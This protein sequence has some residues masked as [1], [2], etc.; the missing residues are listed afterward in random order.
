M[1]G[2]Q[3]PCP[4]CGG[5]VKFRIS[6]SLV[7]VCPFCKSVVARGD[8]ALED[9]GKVADVVETESPLQ[10]GL[11][12]QYE[13]KRL[14]LVGRSQYRHAAGGVWDEWY[15]AFPGDR[16]GWLAEAQ[17]RFYLTFEQKNSSKI[18]LP[19]PGELTLGG[20]V[21]M[22]EAGALTV[23][24]IGR[25]EALTAEGEIPFRFVPGI[26]HEYA[27]LHGPENT[28]ATLS[29]GDEGPI[30]FRG[31][32][33]TLDQLG[34]DRNAKGP[35]REPKAISALHVSCPRCAGPLT[36]VAPDQTQRVACP[37]CMSLLDATQG[38]LKYLETLSAGEY[39][40]VIPLGTIGT[41]SGVSYHVIGFVVRSVT[42]DDTD[43]FWT[44]YLLYQPIDGFRWLVHSDNH[45]SFV[46]PISAGAV[47]ISPGVAHYKGRRF[48]LFQGADATVRHVLGEFYWKVTVGERVRAT[49]F[50]APP[51]ML[52]IESSVEDE[53][54]PSETGPS[55]REVN[56]SLGTYMPHETIEQAFGVS[57]LRR[58]FGVAPNQ[59]SPVDG[60]VYVAWGLF[61][62]ILLILDAMVS[63][64][65]A[66]TGID[67]SFLVAALAL[68]SVVPVGAMIYGH[69]FERSRWK[70][71]EY[72]PY[73][74]GGGDDDDD[75]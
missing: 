10:I 22:G 70:D 72:N 20:T 12:G 47:R 21:E 33:V 23:A 9:L 48:R 45:W 59:P 58:G 16:W 62:V 53:T 46:C 29:L 56:Y 5:P 2:R 50:I 63:A 38:N 67:Q 75:E 55:V 14:M 36:L 30:L 11:R 18:P 71:S 17:G 69:S 35:A 66:P 68:I 6:T 39:H 27:D 13:G 61:A 7:A 42:F 41:L 1:K 8:K 57:D 64:A 52:S 65:K 40:P 15:A 73:D 28:F 51:E 19:S 3:A 49:D 25:A 26:S 4:A 60:R 34:I 43:Y 32:E 54:S 44:E 37:N 74:T 24:E 31:K